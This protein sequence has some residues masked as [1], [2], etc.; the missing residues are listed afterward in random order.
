MA[1]VTLKPGREKSL[2]RRHPWVFSGAIARIDDQPASGETVLVLAH[3]GM[4]QGQGA[5]SP[6]S[7]I[8]VR[9]WTFDERPVD[10]DYFRDGLQK[11][12]GLRLGLL[13]QPNLNAMR[14]VNAESDGLP[15]V[16][17][18]R[19]ASFVVCQFLSAGAERWKREI[20]E[21]LL[22]LLVTAGVEV[23]GIY[24]RSD[25]DARHKEGLPPASGVL[26]GQAPP[27]T[28]VIDEYGCRFAVQISRGH[29]TGFYLDQRE[30]RALVAEYSRG[31]SVLN[32][33]A[34][35][36]AF[37]V[38]ALK[39][40]ALHVTNVEASEP[41][42]VLARENMRLNATEQ[43]RAD[44]VAGDVFEVFRRYR[45]SRQSF[46][47]VVLDPPKFAESRSQV[48]RATRGY[49]DINL[50]AF[51]LLRPGGV[52]FTFSCSG[53]VTPELFQMVVAGAALDAGRPVQ[54]LRRLG[55]ASD[56]PVA[57]NFPEG[58]YLKGLVCR[59]SD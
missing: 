31:R 57:L 12:L 53:L 39:G 19:Y 36:G 8:A 27:E 44:Q 46:D 59:V 48:E 22:E 21:L 15:G 49:K 14:L 35:S 9:M 41:A 25:V 54:I 28:V 3:D 51:K 7:Q 26:A 40:G 6:L 29:K 2:L 16:V 56:H 47:L 34:Y 50:L 38:W 37:A 1:T 55:Q 43:D 17:V 18:D 4:P 24:E 23:S 5:F 45:D 58:E 10:A 13:A 42:L 52:L 30:N 11:A 32:G 20:V 33:F